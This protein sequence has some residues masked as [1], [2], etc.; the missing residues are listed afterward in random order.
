MRRV[1]T[2]TLITLLMLDA[3]LVAAI[4]ISGRTAWAWICLYWILLTLKNFVDWMPAREAHK[5]RIKR[6]E[7]QDGKH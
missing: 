3:A 4:L 7:A 1:I 5:D 6:L 2:Q